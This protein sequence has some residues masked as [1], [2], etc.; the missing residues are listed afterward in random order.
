MREISPVSGDALRRAGA[1]RCIGFLLSGDT[2][3]RGTL[4]ASWIDRGDLRASL[5]REKRFA[6]ALAAEE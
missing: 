6:P 1:P 3:R 5:G 2:S 4:K